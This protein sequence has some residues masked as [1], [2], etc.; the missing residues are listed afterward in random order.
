MASASDGVPTGGAAPPVLHY[1]IK[2][3]VKDRGV[4]S[5]DQVDKRQRFRDGRV[6]A[7]L[8]DCAGPLKEHRNEQLLEVQRNTYR[9][10]R[11]LEVQRNTSEALKTRISAFVLRAV[12][13]SVWEALEHYKLEACGDDRGGGS[14]RDRLP[15]RSS[16]GGDM[17]MPAATTTRCLALGDGDGT[18][19]RKTIG[20]CEGR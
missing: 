10:E 5:I 11:L 18:A 4:G 17:T 15:I 14:R 3:E 19:G 9:N 1:C 13:S 7:G 8:P 16:G 6:P 20:S 2:A 12:A